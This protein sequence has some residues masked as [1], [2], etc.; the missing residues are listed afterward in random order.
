MR[1]GGFAMAAR[2]HQHNTSVAN[3]MAF[4]RDLRTTLAFRMDTHNAMESPTL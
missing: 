1:E 4:K 3:E 2:G